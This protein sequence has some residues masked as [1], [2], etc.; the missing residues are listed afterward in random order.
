MDDVQFDSDVDEFANAA[1]PREGVRGDLTGWFVR[2]GLVRTRRQAEYV[3]LLIAALAILVGVVSWAST[4]PNRK[5]PVITPSEIPGPSGM[6]Y[7]G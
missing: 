6:K 5:P 7:G 2:S 4:R 3:L 1:A